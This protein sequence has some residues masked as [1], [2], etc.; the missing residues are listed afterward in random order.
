MT[1]ENLKRAMRAETCMSDYE[2]NDPEDAVSSI[3]DLISDLCHLLH[4]DEKTAGCMAPADIKDLLEGAYNNFHAE[5]VEP[6]DIEL[7]SRELGKTPSA[8]DFIAGKGGA[9]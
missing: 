6:D 2:A 4:L 3:K 9:S 5:A 1:E 8:L 7:A